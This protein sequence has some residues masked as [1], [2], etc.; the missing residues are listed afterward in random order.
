MTR[1]LESKSRT[2]CTKKGQQVSGCQLA[3]HLLAVSCERIIATHLITHLSASQFSF[4]KSHSAADLNLLLA[5]EWSDALD[6]GKLTAVAVMALDIA[7]AFDCV[8]HAALVE[9][10]HIEGIGR[11]LLQLLHDYLQECKMQVVCNG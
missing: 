9:S 5:S 7:S 1:N 4:R 3:P 6:Q 8:R 11:P 2:A 10:L